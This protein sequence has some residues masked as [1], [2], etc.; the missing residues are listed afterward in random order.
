M[1]L[2]LVCGGLLVN[3]AAA[4]LALWRRRVDPGGAAM[5]VLLGTAIFV[6]VGP[7]AWLVLG[8]FF[9]S[10]TAAGAIGAARRPELSRMHEKGGRRD[11]VQAFANAGPGAIMALLA[12]SYGAPAFA[13]GFA[14]AFAAAAADTWASEIGVLSLRRPR[15]IV[16]LRPVECGLSGGVTGLGLLAGLAGA[17]LIAGMAV[18]VNVITPLAGRRPLALAVVVAGAGF[19]GSVLDSVLGATAQALY[20]VPSTGALTERR[21]V[22]G[23]QT[24]LARGF[25][26]ITNDT[27]NF[28]STS[29]VAA[30]AALAWA[31]LP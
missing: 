15:S 18:A 12:R 30:A 9:L 2:L 20:R 22:D 7:L 10:S 19:L 13:V 14:A 21:E 23:E 31:M 3:V 6:S 11:L 27:V 29:A 17:I 5:G 25:A 1:I 28:V 26:F 4:A 16:S 8:A 24:T